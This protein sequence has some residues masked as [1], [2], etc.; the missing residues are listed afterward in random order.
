LEFFCLPKEKGD[1]LFSDFFA[2]LGQ[3]QRK[4]F[5]LH[6]FLLSQNAGTTTM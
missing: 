4:L 3:W 2:S 5:G 1:I 6:S